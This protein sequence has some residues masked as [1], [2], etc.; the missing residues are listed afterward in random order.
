MFSFAG[1]ACPSNTQA[2][3]RAEKESR[4][5]L[6]IICIIVPRVEYAVATMVYSVQLIAAAVAL[7]ALAQGATLGS[8][9]P[10][11]HGEKVDGKRTLLPDAAAGKAIVV[12][13]GART[14]GGDGTDDW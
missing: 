12:V 10:K 13:V 9:P 14:S 6:A 1:G 3:T 11:L 4:T 7:S 5:R 2:E 8:E